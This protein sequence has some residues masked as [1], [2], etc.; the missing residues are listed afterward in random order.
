[1]VAIT[2][3][4][5]ERKLLVFVTLIILASI[6]M[7]VEL[8]AARHNERSL[9]DQIVNTILVPF[10]SVVT[11]SANAVALEFHTIAHSGSMAAENAALERKVRELA[12]T[13]ER[14]K[15]HAAENVQLRRMLALGQS[16]PGPTI[17]ASVVGYAPE[18]SR[19]E[20]STA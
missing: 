2:S 1:V 3:F 19:R 6:V 10:E 15:E 13:N 14:L 17:A 7:L 18:G 20:I 9:S 11:Q 5:D 8:G 16:M 4:W 12:A